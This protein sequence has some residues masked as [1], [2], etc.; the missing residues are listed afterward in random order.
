M[1][2]EHIGVP[3]EIGCGVLLPLPLPGGS[4]RRLGG[5][6]DFA[7]NP[8]VELR[9]ASLL[10][11]PIAVLRFPLSGVLFLGHNSGLLGFADKRIIANGVSSRQ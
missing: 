2:R 10:L 6:L 3:L 5:L 7:G 4:P 1:E 8:P 11:K 9:G